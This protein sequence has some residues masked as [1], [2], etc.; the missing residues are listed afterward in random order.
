MIGEVYGWVKDTRK[1]LLDYCVS[2]PGDLFAQKREDFGHGSLR[3]TLL[4][5]ADCYRF[6]LAQTVMKRDDKAFSSKDHPD[7]GSV[8]RLF[9]DYVDPLVGEF[10]ARYGGDKL[11]TPFDLRVRWQAEP[12]L[13]SPLWLMTHMITHEFHHKGQIVAFGRILGYP[14]P[15]TDLYLPPAKA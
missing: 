10:L 12:F 2:L 4:H 1:G 14:P 15:E 8:A 5:T 11:R 6:W 3:G 13:A 7:A 9:A